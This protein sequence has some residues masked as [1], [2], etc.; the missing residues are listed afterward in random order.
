LIV[1]AMPHGETIGFA[2]PLIVTPGDID[3]IVEIVDKAVREVMDGL[4]REKSWKAA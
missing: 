3:E 4:V 2:P 1:R